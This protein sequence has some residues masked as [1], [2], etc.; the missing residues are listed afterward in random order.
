LR[1][2]KDWLHIRSARVIL[3]LPTING[4]LYYF[5]D[6]EAYQTCWRVVDDGS[7]MY[8]NVE[9]KVDQQSG[10][11]GHCMWKERLRGELSHVRRMD[12]QWPTLE[13]KHHWRKLKCYGG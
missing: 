4:Y 9:H 7:S 5:N 8:S 11:E 10:S 3:G 2:G 1:I 12:N 6:D 13:V